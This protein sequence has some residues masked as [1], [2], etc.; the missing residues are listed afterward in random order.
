MVLEALFVED[1]LDDVLDEV[2]TQQVLDVDAVGVLGG[3]EDLLDRDRLVVDVLDGDLGLA[4]GTQ[5]V[6]HVGL[7]DGGEALGEP[8]REVD[9]H[10]HQRR[11]LV[12]RVAEH[13]ALVARTDEVDRIDALTVLDLEG[14]VDAL[15][16][17]GALLVHADQD[18]AGL[19]VEAVLRAV[20]ADV[21]DDPAHDRGDVDVAVRADL[22]A[23]DDLPGGGEALDGAAHVVGARLAAGLGLEALGGKLRLARDD[24]VEHGVRDLVAHLVRVTLGHR[25]G[26]EQVLAFRHNNLLCVRP[27]RA[28]LR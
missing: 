15:G 2:G 1:G 23:D 19:A 28:G 13:H 7:A 5:V 12:D 27:A 16:D 6:Q 25:F 9:R 21:L 24:R 17:V 3:D 8:V 14:L 10:R 11:G 18:A 26:R 4:V 20:V 22:A